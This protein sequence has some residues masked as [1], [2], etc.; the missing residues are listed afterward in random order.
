[1]AKIIKSAESKSESKEFS[2][3][4]SIKWVT[5]FHDGRTSLQNTHQGEIVKVCPVNLQVMDAKGNLWSV[6]KTEI[7]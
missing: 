7:A 1:M 2:K 5:Y 4:Q 3:G 6:A